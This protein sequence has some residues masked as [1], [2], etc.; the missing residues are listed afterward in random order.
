MGLMQRLC[1][2]YDVVVDSN[3]SGNIVPIGFTQKE[4]KYHV[5]L[6]VDGDFVSANELMMRDEN[7]K[8]ITYVVPTTPDAESRSGNDAT[9][10]LVEQLK[11]M[12]SDDADS[13][14]RLQSYKKQLEEWCKKGAP[15]CIQAVYKY[16]KKGTL[17]SDLESQRIK[18]KYYKNEEK[19]EG[20]GSDQGSMV[21]FSVQM[22][23]GNADDLLLRDDVKQS[24]T[25]FYRAKYNQ[26]GDNNRLCYISGK[27]MMEMIKYPKVMGNTK[28]I[29]AD[30]SEYLF[31]YKGRFD[32]NSVSVSNDAV[33][34]AHNALNWL[35]D[36]QGLR[37]YGMTWLVWNINGVDM[38]TPIDEDYDFSEDD[39]DDDGC[40]SK[41][42]VDT[43]EGYAKAVNEAAKGYGYKL[44][45]YNSELMNWVVVLGLEAAT[46]GRLS[47]TYYQECP[48]GEYVN[49]IEN[50]YKDCCWWG[51]NRKRNRTEI[52]TPSPNDLAV[53]IMGNDAVNMAK[54]DLKCDKS[55][56]KLMRELLYRIQVCIVDQKCLPSSVVKSAF[57][58]V[59]NPMSFKNSKEQKWFRSKWQASVN[60]TCAMIM[61]YQKR[62]NMKVIYVPELQKKSRNRGYL[63]GR[64]FATADYIEYDAMGVKK[65][66]YSPTN[67]IRLMQQFVQRPVETWR[68]IHDKLV[69]TLLNANE[70][71]NTRYR[72]YLE[73][74]EDLFIDEDRF[75]EKPLSM[76]F[77]QGYSSQWQSF[78]DK[79][80]SSKD[81]NVI[82]QTAVSN[83]ERI[84]DLPNSRSELYGCLLSIADKVEIVGGG[85]E[86]TGK[87]NAMQMMTMFSAR[88]YECWGRLH[89]KIIPYLEKMGDNADYYQY[90]IGLV[91]NQFSQEDRESRKPL[92]GGY[93]HGY[94]TMLRTLYQRTKY[95]TTPKIWAD[96]PKDKRSALFG[97]FLGLGD[98][99]ERVAFV[100]K[101]QGKE[102]NIER[103]ITNELRYMPAFAQK[104]DTTWDSLQI[105]LK[106]YQ[107]NPDRYAHIVEKIRQIEDELQ[108]DKFGTN[109]PLNSIYL[110][111]YYAARNKE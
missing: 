48:G 18:V 35:I 55:Q 24:W 62:A 39:E 20:K 9:F 70:M 52:I 71:D 49:R 65:H 93:L 111:Y 21:C 25:N 3:E 27:R 78:F 80:N 61:C 42:I 53:A 45:E 82:E 94:Y 66:G 84:F 102:E 2:T 108:Q 58:R 23:D 95:N 14:K 105:K 104:P 68:K 79:A 96:E 87:T 76:E 6:T 22:H 64:L 41:P 32:D 86:R 26:A 47:V 110:H 107:K 74:I 12:I 11:Y 10:P 34:R 60:A 8:T 13:N 50:W 91:E 109:E 16:M 29:S 75:V 56:T 106:A 33:V 63:Y 43:Y 83:E 67:A 36:R 81:E 54:R 97:Q 7:G 77:L 72:I 57:N 88:P 98:R 40:E 37:K 38:K 85:D 4:V 92:D 28:L 44:D 1:E 17:L 5:V 90:L 19:K 103:R 31:Q 30:C 15:K 101:N 51:Y 73:N 99:L 59:C 89:D 46:R 69:P 100:I